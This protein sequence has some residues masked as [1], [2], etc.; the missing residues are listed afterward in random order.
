[1]QIYN[2]FNDLLTSVKLVIDNVIFPHSPNLIKS[3]QFNL[4]NRSFQFSKKAHYD[5]QLPAAI[6]SLNDQQETFQ[7]RSDLI[8]QN[9][10]D[11]IN[12]IPVLYNKTQDM[13]L[14]VHEE[15]SSV[16]F[17]IIINTESQLQAKEIAH[18]IK[19][20]LPVNK[21]LQLLKFVSFH[22]IDPFILVN[23]LKF[24][25]LK[26]DVNNLYTRLNNSTGEVINCFAMEYNPL[27]RLESCNSSISDS[28]QSTF[29]VNVDLT[30]NTHF[31]MYLVCEKLKYIKTINLGWNV[32]KSSVM[33]QPFEYLLGEIPNYKTDRTLIIYSEDEKHLDSTIISKS[34]KEVYVN[35]RFELSDFGIT[36]NH[37]FRFYRF[38]ISSNKME[39]IY[40]EEPEFRFTKENRIVFKFTIEEYE[41]IKPIMNQ[42]LFIDFYTEIVRH[43]LKDEDELINESFDGI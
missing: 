29:S 30:Y 39:P 18:Q 16:G 26:D 37:K 28:S 11:N 38:N 8:Q 31:P 32:G 25:L 14:H 3:Y 22:E 34:E 21:N 12:K 20:T 43:Y 19:R 41:K 6:I 10:L 42:P 35:I 4:G 33:M 17:S 9:N 24:N 40:V 13:L 27:I 15:Y 5:Y 2:F 23:D 36:E 1:M 7:R